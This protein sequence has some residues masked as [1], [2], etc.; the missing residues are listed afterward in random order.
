[1]GDASNASR[2]SERLAALGL[3]L[4]TPAKPVAAYIPTRRVGNL[5]YVSG[6]IPLRDG[7]PMEKGI[8]G[9]Q[10]TLAR[11]IECARQ[12]AMNAVAAAAGA[13]GGVDALKGV[14]RVG[15]F[16]AAGPAFTEHSKVANG[17]SDFMVEV[18][19]EAGRHA[20]AAV[21]CSSLP[22]GVPVE[23]EVVFEC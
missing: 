19:A 6:Q 11:A 17:A 12:C 13:V 15:V 23:V 21:G 14:V 5:L 18:F 1:M 20:R 4:P 8:T 22:L 2:P 7:V 9:E 16:V 3:T 10:V